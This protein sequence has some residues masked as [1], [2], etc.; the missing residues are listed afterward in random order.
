MSARRGL[1]VLLCVGVL[2]GAGSAEAG[3]PLPQRPVGSGSGGMRASGTLDGK[4]FAAVSAIIARDFY[5]DLNVY[6][7]AAR[8][9]CG[10]VSTED[11]PLLWISIDSGGRVPGA[12]KAIVPASG[13]RLAARVARGSR[14]VAIQDG[15]SIT[16]TH[17]DPRVGSVWHG[18]IGIGGTGAR[19]HDVFAGS[20]AARWCGQV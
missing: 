16:F 15:I 19:A 10:V 18:S 17:L 9:G 4:P 20:F 14:Q 3:T 6:L 2:V 7:F 8:R 12:G 11:A 13:V 5:G 1:V